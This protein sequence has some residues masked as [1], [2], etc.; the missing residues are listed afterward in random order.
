MG[1]VSQARPVAVQSPQKTRWN[2]YR[3]FRGCEL[4]RAM[5]CTVGG[6]NDKTTMRATAAT[7]LLSR[8]KDNASTTNGLT[9]KSVERLKKHDGVGATKP[10]VT[11]DSQLVTESGSTNCVYKGHE[12]ERGR[13]LCV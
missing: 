2:A 13:D 7:R 12:L 6:G 8:Q 10:G 1:R 4:K 9:K 11:C 3:V 5:T